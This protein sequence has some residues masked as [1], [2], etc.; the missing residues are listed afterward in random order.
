MKRLEVGCII[1]DCFGQDFVSVA[2]WLIRLG[3]LV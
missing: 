2:F 3:W 1:S